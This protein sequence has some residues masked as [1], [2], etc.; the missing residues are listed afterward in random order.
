MSAVNAVATTDTDPA[1]DEIHLTDAVVQQPVLQPYVDSARY[2]KCVEVSKRIRWDIDRDVIRGREFDFTK[3][4]LPDGLSFVDRLSFLNAI[5]CRLLSQIQGRS[6]ANIFGLVERFIGA[7][8]LDVSRDHW[9][10]DQIALEALVRF[11]DEELKHQEL[12]RRIETM[13]GMGMPAGYTFDP[14]PDEVA[15]FVLAKSTWAVLA[16][17]C[18]IELFTQAHYRASIEPDS[19]LSPLFKEV[20]L[21]HWKEESQHAILDELEWVRE[22][23]KL[24]SQDL[25]V[26]VDD[27]IALVRAVDEILQAQAAADTRYFIGLC[28]RPKTPVEIESVMETVL[29]AYRFQYIVSGVQIPRFGAMLNAMTTPAQALRISE[30]LAPIMD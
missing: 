25:D 8:V 4:F 23:A 22:N 21:F 14:Q 3:K 29:A 26:A 24:S 12:F 9:L 11:T 1:Q 16:L 13:I 17:T 6:Y 2:A 5:E 18:L 7:K 20:F 28:S 27:L 19:E 30:A 10:G 15:S